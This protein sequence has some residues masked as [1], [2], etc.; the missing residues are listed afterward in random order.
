A[1]LAALPP[2]RLVYAAAADFVPQGSFRPARGCRGVHVLRRGDVRQ[3]R[4]LAV[5]GALSCVPGPEARFHLANADDEGQRRAALAKW[6]SDARNPL[7]WRS[8]VNRVWHYHFGRGLVAT[9]SDFGR[10]GARPTH[11]EL[12]DW[13]TA[14]FLESGG[15][16]KKLHRLIVTSSTYLQ[17]SRHH[18][19]YAKLDADNAF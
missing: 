3:P 6:V 15:S 5:P 9:P 7:T 14:T 13:L 8:I 1:E 12:L 19:A 2:Q 10:M 4:A 11:P 16:L 18:P 17:S